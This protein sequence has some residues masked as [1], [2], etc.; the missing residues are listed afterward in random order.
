[1][2]HG[3]NFIH[4]ELDL[5]DQHTLPHL[6]HGATGLGRYS[7]LQPVRSRPQ[8]AIYGTDTSAE[9]SQLHGTLH[10][11][12]HILDSRSGL[13]LGFLCQQSVGHADRDAVLPRSPRSMDNQCS[14]QT[15]NGGQNGRV[16]QCRLPTATLCIN[17]QHRQPTDDATLKL[18]VV[19]LMVHYV[20]PK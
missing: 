6:C 13:L 17:A 5:I 20:D 18:I 12:I 10:Q 16:I 1:M 9:L 8:N 4:T 3:A 11:R 2:N 19:Q 14:H 7:N 15:D